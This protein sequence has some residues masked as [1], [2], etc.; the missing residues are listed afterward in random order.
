MKEEYINLELVKNETSHRFEMTVEGYTA[1][2]DYKEKT[3]NMANTYG[4]PERIGRERCCY[5]HH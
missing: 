4:S 2:I 3:E 5:C 1:F